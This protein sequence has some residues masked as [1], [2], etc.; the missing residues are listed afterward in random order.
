MKEKLKKYIKILK[1][2]FEEAIEYLEYLL[3]VHRFRE[4]KG[5]ITHYVYLE[6]ITVLTNE[7]SG[8]KNFLKIV[9]SLKAEDFQDLE[10][11]ILYLEKQAVESI[12][13]FDYPEAVHIMC[14]R[15]LEKVK[16]FVVES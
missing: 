16:R 14:Q 13:H 9:K 6:N 4:E 7:L 12:K 10:S 15:K 2:E 11:L 5:E 8:I 1:I 3:E